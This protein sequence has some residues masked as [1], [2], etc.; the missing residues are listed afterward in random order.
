MGDVAKT[1]PFFEWLRRNVNV[2]EVSVEAAERLFGGDAVEQ[3]VREGWLIPKGER[4]Q[5][6][7]KCIMAVSTPTPNF[8]LSHF[9]G[10]SEFTFG[11]VKAI[12]RGVPDEEL[13]GVIGELLRR[14]AVVEV[15]KDRYRI[16]KR[17]I[18][19]H[20]PVGGRPRLS[21]RLLITRK[22]T[23]QLE[24]EATA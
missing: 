11:E 10:R 1:I 16:L 22:N 3:L 8:L 17:Y 12:F 6:R 9:E 14:R 24:L 4:L 20:K 23:I 21:R 18:R 7:K 2:R 13:R 5:I 19:Y 15:A